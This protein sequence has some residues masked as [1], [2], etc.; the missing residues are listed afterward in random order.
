MDGYDIQGHGHGYY[1]QET[2]TWIRYSRN[3]KGEQ[4]TNSQSW[5]Y[6]CMF[7]WA[8][9]SVRVC[10]LTES[11]CSALMCAC[12]FSLMVLRQ[13]EIIMWSNHFL[14]STRRVNKMAPTGISL[15]PF[16]FVCQAVFWICVSMCV[17][18]FLSITRF[19]LFICCFVYFVVDCLNWEFKMSLSLFL[20]L[21]LYL[22]V[23]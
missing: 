9:S 15:Q 13:S 4:I 22:S 12:V 23:S 19:Y 8:V 20:S 10:Y 6:V 7:D 5:L 1:I 3:M 16:V 21:S 17:N 11:M 14:H 18:Y 2:W